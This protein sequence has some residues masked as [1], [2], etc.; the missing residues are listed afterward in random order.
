MWPY[1]FGARCV[2]GTV[3]G[4]DALPIGVLIGELSKGLH[5][6]MVRPYGFAWTDKGRREIDAFVAAGILDR[7]VDGYELRCTERGK[8]WVR[9]HEA[10]I[11]A[12]YHADNPWRRPRWITAE[13]NAVTNIVTVT[14]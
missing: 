13:R 2:S 8:A 4:M 5:A 14:P 12:A 3:R 1:R 9:E 7:Y 6:T 10:A 11:A